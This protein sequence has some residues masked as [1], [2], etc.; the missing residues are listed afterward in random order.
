MGN[1]GFQ[2]L[3][4]FDDLL[5]D[6]LV[7]KVFYWATIRKVFSRGQVRGVQRSQVVNIIRNEI[8]LS[9]RSDPKCIPSVYRAVEQFCQLPPIHNYLRRFPD[10]LVQL[11]FQKHVKL[12]MQMYLPE[13][14]FEVNCTDRYMKKSHEIEACIV[15]RKRFNENEDI[16]YLSGNLV[17]LSEDEED[18][19]DR[20][21]KVFSIINLHKNKGGTHLMLGP[22]RFVNHD[23]NS[24]ARFCIKAGLLGIKTTRRI[25][26]GEEITATYSIDYFGDENRDCLCS[27]C[28]HFGK[29]GYDPV[30][31]A[32]NEVRP[33]KT[34]K[35]I[36][37]DPEFLTESI[38]PLNFDSSD[39][40]S[41]TSIEPEEYG[42][43]SCSRS[44]RAK[45]AKIYLNS[46]SKEH[47]NVSS[48]SFPPSLIT[49]DSHEPRNRSRRPRCGRK[50][51]SLRRMVKET[52]KPGT[53]DAFDIGPM[54]N[55]PPLSEPWTTKQRKSSCGSEI[56]N[57][58]FEVLSPEM[59]ER[60]H[61]LT[62][63]YYTS[64]FVFDPAESAAIAKRQKDHKVMELRVCTNCECPFLHS[65]EDHLVPR[66]CH[67]CFRHAKVFGALWPL[68]IK[69]IKS[70]P[71]TASA[72]GV[73]FPSL[74]NF[75]PDNM[76]FLWDE[77]YPEYHEERA[78][79]RL[80]RQKIMNRSESV[81][82]DTPESH[83][84][85]TTESLKT[86]TVSTNSDLLSRKVRSH[87]YI[88][89]HEKS[90]TTKTVTTTTRESSKLIVKNYKTS[91]SLNIK[92]G[93]DDDIDKKNRKLSN[94]D[95]GRVSRQSLTPILES[96]FYSDKLAFSLANAI[97]KTAIPKDV[98]SKKT[99]YQ[100]KDFYIPQIIE[101]D[102]DPK[103]REW[104]HYVR[105]TNY[106]D[107]EVR[108]ELSE[109]PVEKEVI[110]SIEQENVNIRFTRALREKI[111]DS[112]EEAKKELLR[113]KAV[114]SVKRPVSGSAT[115][116]S[117]PKKLLK[118]EKASKCLPKKPTFE[119]DTI[120]EEEGDVP[121]NKDYK[122]EN[123][124]E[125]QFTNDFLPT[126]VG[127]MNKSI[128]NSFEV[129]GSK[130]YVDKA[131]V[132]NIT[133]PRCENWE[134]SQC[135][136]SN[137][138]NLTN[139]S[140][141]CMSINKDND[142][143]VSKTKRQISFL[144]LNS[145]LNEPQGKFSSSK[146]TLSPLSPSLLVDK[147]ISSQFA[148]KNLDASSSGVLKDFQPSTLCT[149]NIV[150]ISDE[151]DEDRNRVTG[152]VEISDESD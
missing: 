142:D 24:N 45:S 86:I 42:V 68:T 36:K 55:L 10:S 110:N 18:E 5:T 50:D 116:S 101:E 90:E 12:Y 119:S 91:H 19:I 53:K 20:L 134:L 57:Y 99:H 98:A 16:K 3:S 130:E 88:K 112:P 117:S 107:P 69:P 6:A 48:S 81:L 149:K 66:Y 60:Y 120:E 46:N 52:Y 76:Y 61:F 143:L 77:M 94:N 40:R 59:K 92:S 83:L 102:L 97:N 28:E 30:N 72:V 43:I 128:C 113:L 51:Y 108:R 115:A 23:C 138:K 95:S 56:D 139:E 78:K 29:N 22:L 122:E 33:M 123:T 93:V 41:P 111:K 54:A 103:T 39:T 67:R 11:E 17:K 9:E 89:Q 124:I 82:S 44:S 141:V 15:A 32:A 84:E 133:I 147:N 137:S 7:D 136:V 140:L 132:V 150:V 109:T 148:A 121:D 14:G 21:K 58:E 62:K 106:V 80:L 145:I 1:L 25:E 71:V 152:V 73:A 87:R 131:G 27:D 4:R 35:N 75:D 104:K 65:T 31:I 70:S 146:N 105:V 127:S 79:K 74:Y 135:T 13:C 64:S 85:L 34:K 8:V 49:I 129:S 126:D 47:T 63:L 100:A 151:S 37:V 2:E 125:L 96:Q 118:S 38:S 114:R 26:I 144:E